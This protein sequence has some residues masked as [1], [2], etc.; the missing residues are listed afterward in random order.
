MRLKEYKGKQDTQLLTKQ[1]YFKF[2][3]EVLDSG[4]TVVSQRELLFLSCKG[5]WRINKEAKKYC[6]KV[7]KVR[8]R[9]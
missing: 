3:I 1:T 6:D 7:K 8:D 2:L 9:E 5:R 4:N